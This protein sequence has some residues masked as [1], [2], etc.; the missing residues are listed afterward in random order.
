MA[1]GTLLQPELCLYSLKPKRPFHKCFD[2]KPNAADAW[3]AGKC[4]FGDVSAGVAATAG[5]GLATPGN[6]AAPTSAVVKPYKRTLSPL[7]GGAARTG[8]T[9]C[10]EEISAEVPGC[11]HYSF[12]HSSWGNFCI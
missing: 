4:L 8:G 11:T 2:K 5:K 9:T 10:A 6:S 12:V 7:G 1:D 3:W